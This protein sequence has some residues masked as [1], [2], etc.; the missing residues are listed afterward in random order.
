MKTITSEWFAKF[1]KLVVGLDDASPAG[2]VRYTRIR[3]SQALFEVVDAI[4][5][6][7][8]EIIYKERRFVDRLY[9]KL[10]TPSNLM[11]KVAGVVSRVAF[12]VDSPCPEC[13]SSP[14]CLPSCSRF[15]KK[16]E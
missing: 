11:S 1:G 16:E 10:P 6:K 3:L 14:T 13:K 12:A 7:R 5:E 9:R 2:R 4:N 8:W 15:V